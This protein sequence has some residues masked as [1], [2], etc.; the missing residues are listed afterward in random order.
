MRHITPSAPH[1]VSSDSEDGADVRPAGHDAP[2]PPRGAVQIRARAVTWAEATLDELQQAQKLHH[3]N[4]KIWYGDD[5]SGARAPLEAL[6]Q[7]RSRLRARGAA[8]E[9]V[10][11]FA[12]E[13]PGKDGDGPRSFIQACYAPEIIFTTAHRGGALWAEDWLS[14]RAVRVPSGLDIYV[15]GWVCRDVST[16][17]HHRN[18]PLLP[19]TDPRVRDGSAG[20]SSKT[21]ES[22]MEYVRQ[23]RPAI[24]ILENVVSKRSVELVQEAFKRI[25]GYTLIVLLVDSR[26]LGACMSRRRMYALAVNT[27]RLQLVTPIEEWPG[28]IGRIA[29]RITPVPL[30]VALMPSAKDTAR[31]TCR[32]KMNPKWTDIHNTIRRVLL[33]PTRKE[34]LKTT[35]THSPHAASLTR[36]M[37][38]LL[39]MHWEVAVRNGISP[40]EHHFVWDL[41]N[42]VKFFGCAKDHRSAGIVPCALRGH[43]LW[44]TKLGR[45]LTGTE[46]MRVQG[47]PPK[48]VIGT[49][50]E[51]VLKS[52]AGDTISV[53]PIGCILAVVLANTKPGRGGEPQDAGSVWIG[54][55]AQRG[56]DTSLDNLMDMAMTK[57]GIIGQKVKGCKKRKRRNPLSGGSKASR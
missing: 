30:K 15:A 17:N 14:K 51:A 54:P 35:V 5:C 25:G 34:L 3:L 53:A 6:Q 55:S 36:R 33:L 27:R 28:E 4:W 22:S 37:Q 44:D 45:Q 24:V 49:V 20:E 21:L 8:F 16:M 39:G 23:H 38:D 52:L 18:K 56:F 42:S 11:K 26:T 31:L 1:S 13:C 50:P 57:A 9:I 46:L 29:K 47:F 19:G 48:S 12:S 32:E 43:T 41:T 2:A 10:D 7:L 40:S